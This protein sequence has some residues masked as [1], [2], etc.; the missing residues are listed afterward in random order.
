MKFVLCIKREDFGDFSAEDLT[1]G[2]LYEVLEDADDQGMLRVRDNSGE[3]YLYPAQFFETVSLS[4]QT[5]QR[6]HDL[7]TAA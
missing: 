6:L 7:L 4:E 1:L 5:A 2:R 3:D